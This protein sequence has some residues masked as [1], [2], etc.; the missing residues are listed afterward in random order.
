MFAGHMKYLP[1]EAVLQFIVL[2]GKVRESDVLTR[3][4]KEETEVE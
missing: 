1:L 3:L 2:L 4:T